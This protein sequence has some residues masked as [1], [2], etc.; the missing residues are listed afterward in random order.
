[1]YSECIGS[2]ICNILKFE[3]AIS[4]RSQLF[5]FYFYKKLYS[6][7][8]NTNFYCTFCKIYSGIETWSENI[9]LQILHICIISS[10]LS[11]VWVE[12]ILQY[13]PISIKYVIST[14]S[15]DT[16]VLITFDLQLWLLDIRLKCANNWS[17][18]VFPDK[19]FKNTKWDFYK[20]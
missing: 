16:S 4:N 20:I 19:M 2:C 3:N 9:I 5:L 12:E 8:F 7:L 11:C 15:H 10:I 6:Q 17:M 13:L 1:M 18:W 14:Y